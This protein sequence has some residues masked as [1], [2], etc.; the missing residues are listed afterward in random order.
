M[1]RGLGVSVALPFLDSMVPAQTPLSK[2]AAVSPSRLA[3]IEIV[4]GA[5][6]STV[7]GSNKHYWSPEKVGA[8]FEFTQTLKPF[9]PFRDYVTVVTGTDLIPATSHSP[10]EEGADHFRSSAA[11][12]TA[13]HPEDDRGRGYL[14]RH[15][16]RPDLRAEVRT[17]HA[18]PFD[19]A[20]HRKSGW[21]GSLRLRLCLRLRGHHQLGISDGSFADDA[22]SAHGVRNALRRWRNGRRASAARGN[23]RQHSRLDFAQRHA[24]SEGPGARRS[25]APRELS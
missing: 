17:G 13:A 21:L 23:Q 9:E 19:S 14:L 10:K 3:C 6:G 8:D 1:L 12:L 25:R 7:D 2:T 16:H 18:H 11:Y 5:A 4:H 15:F 24:A 22:R 20:L